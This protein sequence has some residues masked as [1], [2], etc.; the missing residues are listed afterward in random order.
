M[1]NIRLGLCCLNVT[2]REQKPSIFASRSMTLDGVRKYGLSELQ[3]RTLANLADICTMIEWNE[4]HNIKVFRLSS[5][6]FPQFTNPLILDILRDRGDGEYNMLFAR[7]A[8]AKIGELANKYKHRITFHPSHYNVLATNNPI[9][10]KKTI[11]DLTYHAD[12]LEYMNCGIDSVM[13]VHG[14]GTYGDKNK[15]IKRWCKQYKLLPP[16]VKRRLVLENDER[17]YSIADCLYV[18][19]IVG[20]PV[21]FDIFHHVCYT[22]THPNDNMQ[23]PEI[24]IPQIL[25]TWGKIRPKFHLSEQGNGK[26]GNHSDYVNVIPNCLLDIP[27]KYNIG[28]DI[29]IE[30]KMKELAIQKLY[31][32]YPNLKA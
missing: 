17:N 5:E 8:L 20:V 23:P 2:L 24:Y 6:I 13:V 11:A 3:A 21:C 7:E 10:L 22:K 27:K 12:M 16:Y 14:G 25:E 30:A 9:A 31:K 32:K 18:S 1:S 4:K 29:M 15:S 26:T 28:I 19:S